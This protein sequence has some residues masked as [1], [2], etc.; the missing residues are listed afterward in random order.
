MTLSLKLCQTVTGP[1][2]GEGPLPTVGL[3]IP[4]LRQFRG[5]GSEQLSRW[6]V[7]FGNH[8]QVAGVSGTTVM[9]SLGGVRAGVRVYIRHQETGL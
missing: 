4:V 1:A 3:H 8:P 7:L 2:V 9:G 6:P 5:T